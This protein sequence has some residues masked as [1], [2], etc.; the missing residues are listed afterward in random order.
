M[1]FRPGFF[2]G[3]ILSM[4]VSVCITGGCVYL[5]SLADA[6]DR[7]R[8]V[9][10][11]VVIFWVAFLVV[12]GFFQLVVL[13]EAKR[14]NKL[15]SKKKKKKEKDAVFLV[16]RPGLFNPMR[17][18]YEEVFTFTRS[19]EREIDELKKVETFRR[20]FIA[21]VSHELKTPLFAAQ[22]F[23]HTLI[24]G[25]AEDDK[26]RGRFLKKAAKSLD[27]LD[28][29]V[30]DILMLSQIETG[31][32]KMK[33]EPV[34]LLR[35]T[36]EVI[37]QLEEEAARKKVKLIIDE[38]RKDCTVLADVQRITQVVTNL[39]ANA[40]NYN[41]ENGDVIVQFEITKKSVITSV[42]DT[43]LGIPAEHLPRVFERFYRVDKSRSR[44]K[45]GTG[46]GLAIV[47][48]ILEGHNTKADV[49]SMVGKGSTFSFKLPRFRQEE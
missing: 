24:D 21:N 6:F 32:I 4:F 9:S 39:V 36:R 37:E 14:I 23:I 11:G 41:H 42:R 8:L 3:W 12:H 22:G 17:G 33:F 18:I 29:L 19:K 46:L 20:D 38:T 7:S 25:A 28:H 44:E 5:L 2:D 26:V 47:K 48:H 10:V 31:A 49:T 30:Q 13:R 1:K 34:D 45:G 27:S 35:V 15:L 40:I 16:E 43:G